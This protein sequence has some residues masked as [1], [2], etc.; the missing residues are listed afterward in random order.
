MRLRKYFF[1]RQRRHEFLSSDRFSTHVNS[2]A[3]I[4]LSITGP[5]GLKHTKEGGGGKNSG[6]VRVSG[7]KMV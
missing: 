4:H 5:V 3:R 7:R 6:K 1:H 2:G